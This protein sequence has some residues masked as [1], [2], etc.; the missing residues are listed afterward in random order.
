[1]VTP[2]LAYPPMVFNRLKPDA[3]AAKT[4]RR[5]V[6]GVTAIVKPVVIPLLI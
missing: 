5:L 6:C 2:A 4:R 1:M 3:V